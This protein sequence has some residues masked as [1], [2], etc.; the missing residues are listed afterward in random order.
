ML[1]TI[2]YGVSSLVFGIVLFFPLRKL[3][4]AMSIN[5]QQR[6][7][8]REVT[9][10]ERENLRRKVTIVAAAVAVTFAF[11]Y[12]KFLFFKFFQQP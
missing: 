8:G 6:R 7:L 3:M 2:W 4:L 1:G 9:A 12:N 10:E 11:F 5:R